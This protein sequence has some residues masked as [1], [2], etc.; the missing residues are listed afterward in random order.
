MTLF[1]L[2]AGTL[3]CAI[4]AGCSLHP[5]FFYMRI[6]HDLAASVAGAVDR[7]ELRL[8]VDDDFPDTDYFWEDASDLGQVLHVRLSTSK[9]LVE[10]GNRKGLVGRVRW[11]FCDKPK[12]KVSLGYPRFFVDAQDSLTLAMKSWGMVTRPMPSPAADRHGRF[13]YDAIMYVRD[14]PPQNEF[15]FYEPFDL[16]RELRDVCVYVLI[17][18]K[19]GGYKTNAARIPKEEI[20]AAL[21]IEVAPRG[22]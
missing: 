11:Y 22:G 8:L 20:A 16:E 3:A 2:L 15:N 14:S 4:L 17:P 13:A 21:G 1:R 18:G 7:S 19:L 12:Q 5:I 10:F 9:D 6:R